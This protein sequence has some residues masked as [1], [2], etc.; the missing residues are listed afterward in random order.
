MPVRESAVMQKLRVINLRKMPKLTIQL[1]LA[2][3]IWLEIV[4][5]LTKFSCG[6]AVH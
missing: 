4:W 3:S 6:W 1:E 5:Q 2:L